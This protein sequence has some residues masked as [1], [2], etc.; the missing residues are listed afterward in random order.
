MRRWVAAA[1]AVTVAS[2]MGCGPSDEAGEPVG[3]LTGTWSG[4]WTGP[5][6]SGFTWPMNVA[7]LDLDQGSGMVI[8]GFRIVAG[9]PFYDSTVYLGSLQGEVAA[10]TF[11]FRLDFGAGSYRGSGRVWRSAGRTVLALDYAGVSC[12]G[13]PDGGHDRL[14]RIDSCPAGHTACVEAEAPYCADLLGDESNCGDCGSAC[15]RELVC[16]RGLCAWPPAA[17]GGPDSR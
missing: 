9:P 7:V 16:D 17:A 15:P 3:D 13:Y 10:E 6:A 14:V 5:G 4:A 2:M 11:S 1:A 12:C 8:G